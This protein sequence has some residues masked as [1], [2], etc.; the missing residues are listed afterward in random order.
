MDEMTLAGRAY[1]DPFP[2]SF[3]TDLVETGP[4]LGGS[5][6]ERRAAELVAEAFETAG[7][8]PEIRAFDISR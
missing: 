3:L 1:D 5:P 8:D 4:R 2:W 7:A 6:G